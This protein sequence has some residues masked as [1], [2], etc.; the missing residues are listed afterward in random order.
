DAVRDEPAAASRRP[1]DR[2]LQDRLSRLI[3]RVTAAYEAG[4]FH[5]GLQ[6]IRAFCARDL[7]AVYL[8]AADAP[9]A[10]AVLRQTVEA[11]A[12]LLAPTA[13]FLADELWAR[14]PGDARPLSAQLADWPDPPA[15]WR[16]D[17]LAAQWMVALG[18]C[19]R[20][21]RAVRPVKKSLLA[22]RKIVIYAAGEIRQALES[23]EDA[24]ASLIGA[25]AVECAPRDAAS[26]STLLPDADLT[27]RIADA[28][29]IR[30]GVE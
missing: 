20:I 4:A 1:V 15:A 8:T 10:P 26:G 28:S 22:T 23:T 3:E 19:R 18:A 2:W 21:R 9:S 25:G 24:L 14:L 12:R 11:L 30:P 5:R 6:A 16:D 17:A 13:S 29:P 7:S 27:L